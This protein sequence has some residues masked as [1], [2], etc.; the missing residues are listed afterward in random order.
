MAHVVGNRVNSEG[1]T[2]SE[3]IT[4]VSQMSKREVYDEFLQSEFGYQLSELNDNITGS[5]KRWELQTKLQDRISTFIGD[6]IT[7]QNSLASKNEARSWIPDW[8][9]FIPDSTEHKYRENLYNP[10]ASINLDPENLAM[11]A[12]YFVEHI[13]SNA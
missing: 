3:A 8:V 4:D 2:I 11:V 9:P 10:L 1:I 12:D 7:L 6:Y 13:E 5:T